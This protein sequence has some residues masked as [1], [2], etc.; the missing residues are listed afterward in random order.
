MSLVLKEV[1]FEHCHACDDAWLTPGREGVQL[2]LGGDDGGGELG[3]SCGSGAGAPDLRGDVVK[4]LAVLV[5]D[6]WSAGCSCV[7]GDLDIVS[8]CSV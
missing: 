2:Q 8:M 4:L 5:G 6:D 1:L 7:G 3:V